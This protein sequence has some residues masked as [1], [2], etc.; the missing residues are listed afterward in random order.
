[1]KNNEKKMPKT[2]ELKIRI[3]TIED[4]GDSHIQAIAKVLHDIVS[5]IEEKKEMGFKVEKEK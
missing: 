5:L 1:M 4:M 2:E 3:Q